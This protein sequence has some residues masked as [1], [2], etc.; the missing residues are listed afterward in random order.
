MKNRVWRLSGRERV[1]VPPAWPGRD[2]VVQLAEESKQA[3]GIRVVETVAGFGLDSQLQ[4]TDKSTPHQ[5]PTAFA[6]G[7]CQSR[8][9]RDGEGGR[10]VPSRFSFAPFE[11]MGNVSSQKP[12]SVM[13]RDHVV[14]RQAVTLRASRGHAVFGGS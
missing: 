13:N 6:T 9:R 8:D 1:L 14:I 2:A 12:I 5:R 10:A 11:E 3:L 4:I 7:T